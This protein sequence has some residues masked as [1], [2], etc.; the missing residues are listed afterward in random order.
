MKILV[1]GGN[2]F[3]GK[4]LV[5]KLLNQSHKVTVLN[6][7]GS[8]PN[9]SKKISCALPCIYPKIKYLCGYCIEGCR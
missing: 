7:S 4:K 3:V 6:R 1:I 9:G 5:T 8:G 2:R